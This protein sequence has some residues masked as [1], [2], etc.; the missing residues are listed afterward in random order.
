MAR[1][2]VCASLDHGVGTSTDFKSDLE[3]LVFEHLFGL[4][5]LFG[6][7]SLVV[8]APLIVL[9]YHLEKHFSITFLLG[10]LRSEFKDLVRLVD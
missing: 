8:D 3:V 7:I 2:F 6:L 10:H 1:V 4:C 9:V 5:R